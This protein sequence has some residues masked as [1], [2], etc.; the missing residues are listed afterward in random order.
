[1]DLFQQ[2]V[3]TLEPYKY[4]ND[5]TKTFR[6]YND[7]FWY[8][9]SLSGLVPLLVIAV[10]RF[11]NPLQNEKA[12]QDQ[13]NFKKTKGY[14]LVKSLT[15]YAFY[16]YILDMILTAIDGSYAN[17]CRFAF[18]SHHVPSV[19]LLY[20]IN[21]LN[22]MPWWT[23]M[24]AAWHALLIAFPDFQLLNYPYLAII[25]YFHYMIFYKEPYC[26][27]GIFKSIQKVFPFMYIAL[28]IIW[29]TDCKNLLPF[30]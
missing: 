17:V 2:V 28:V 7:M 20:L 9:Y 15:F 11:F 29:W 1:M 8:T 22:Y 12:L 18:L 27:M 24:V 25:F 23:I 10:Y 21:S 16:Y 5:W 6:Y 3:K 13:P 19:P 14:F 4:E 26:T 30:I